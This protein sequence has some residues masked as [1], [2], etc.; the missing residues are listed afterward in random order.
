MGDFDIPNRTFNILK[1]LASSQ[2]I[3]HLY[4]V[5]SFIKK[6]EDLLEEYDTLPFIVDVE[7][8]VPIVLESIYNLSNEKKVD[9]YRNICNL[10][11]S[12][13]LFK[14]CDKD[15]VEYIVNE[16]KKEENKNRRKIKSVAEV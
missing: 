14:N 1:E 5:V 12:M 11:D 7:N 13:A 8:I 3:I 15:K 10:I 9:Y 2:D 6:Q 16:Q 4:Q